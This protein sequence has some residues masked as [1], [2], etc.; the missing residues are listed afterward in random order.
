[1]ARVFRR[2][3]SDFFYGRFK[4]DGKDVWFSTKTAD[5]KDAQEFADAKQKAARG[6]GNIDDYFNG[7]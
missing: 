2:P 6:E 7:L 5:R 1:M 3:G 4:L